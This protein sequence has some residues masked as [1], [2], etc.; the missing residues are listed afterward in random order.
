SELAERGF[1]L[2]VERFDAVGETGFNSTM[3]ALLAEGLCDPQRFD[4]GEAN[5]HRSRELSAEDDFASQA[6]WRMAQARVL[7]HRGEHDEAV[8]LADE[9][10]AINQTTDSL[11]DRK[12]TPL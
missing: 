7:S 2:G 4:E 12:S 3:T 1:R 5:V 9:A 8:A 10:V 11:S 6:A